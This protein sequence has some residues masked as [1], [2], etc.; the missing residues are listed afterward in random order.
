MLRWIVLLT[1]LCLPHTGCALAQ[2]KD[3][4]YIEPDWF[5]DDAPVA[6]A[7]TTDP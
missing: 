4:V 6:T 7:P 2:R 1:V 5:Y 3:V